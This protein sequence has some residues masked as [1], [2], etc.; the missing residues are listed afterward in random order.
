M[1]I[2]P[3][4]LREDLKRAIESGALRREDELESVADKLSEIFHSDSVDLVELC[5]ALEEQRG[6]FP[7][8]VG[9]LIDLLESDGPDDLVSPA[10][11]K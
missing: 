11:R 3:R 4:D 1:D 10:A 7:K 2:F 5:M 6:R 9:E 8:T